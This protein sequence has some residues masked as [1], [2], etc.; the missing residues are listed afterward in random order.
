MYNDGTNR[1]STATKI[2]GDEA[3]YVCQNRGNAFVEH[4]HDGKN[5]VKYICMQYKLFKFVESVEYSSSV[6]VDSLCVALCS[7]FNQGAVCQG[8]ALCSTVFVRH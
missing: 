1:S 8:P 2:G 5:T 4:L 3:R 7:G 6:L